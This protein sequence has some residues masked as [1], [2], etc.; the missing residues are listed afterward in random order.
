MPPAGPDV[1]PPPTPG[2]GCNPLTLSDNARS[3]QPFRPASR[4]IAPV[5]LFS[6]FFIGPVESRPSLGRLL[7]QKK[8]SAASKTRKATTPTVPPT[9]AP[10][11]V[12]D[13]PP[14]SPE[15]SCA[16]LGG[17]A[18]E[19]VETLVYAPREG[20]IDTSVVV[21]SSVVALVAVVRVRVVMGVVVGVVT[22]GPMIVLLQVSDPSSTG[23]NG[24]AQGVGDGQ[25]IDVGRERSDNGVSIEPFR[26]AIGVDLH[27][28]TGR[29]IGSND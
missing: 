4:S 18:V 19:L 16:A 10:T 7:R 9:I 22:T 8:R 23:A 29:T 6:D 28:S 15:L 26:Q 1:G 27:V 21:I 11:G 12:P 24:C 3:A 14:P 2:P 13:L 17:K 25:T 20:L 5:L